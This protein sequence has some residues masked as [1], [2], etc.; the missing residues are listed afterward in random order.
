MAITLG[1]EER[2]RGRSDKWFRINWITWKGRLVQCGTGRTEN[3]VTEHRFYHHHHQTSKRAMKTVHKSQI[4]LHLSNYRVRAIKSSLPLTSTHIRHHFNDLLSLLSFHE[5]QKRL[6]LSPS[7]S[8][9]SHVSIKRK[10]S[11]TFPHLIARC[12]FDYCCYRG[13]RC[14]SLNFHVQLKLFSLFMNMKI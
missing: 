9:K 11:T 6:K 8:L 5:L 13:E 3:C 2:E 10:H 12:A 14:F 1:C 4:P 7:L